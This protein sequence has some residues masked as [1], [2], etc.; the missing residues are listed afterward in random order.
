M[1][2]GIDCRGTL[3]R[4]QLTEA[5][6]VV[7]AAVAQ[8]IRSRAAAHSL[9]TADETSGGS[10]SFNTDAL[11]GVLCAGDDGEETRATAE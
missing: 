1:E 4:R 9:R 7:V 10:D 3:Q 8:C 11:K 5:A 2:Q 6:C